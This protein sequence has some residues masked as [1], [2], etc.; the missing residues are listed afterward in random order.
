[1]AIEQIRSEGFPTLLV[2]CGGIVAYGRDARV[3]AEVAF[4]YMKMMGYDAINI[5]HK[6]MLIG[7]D[8]LRQ[9]SASHS[10]PS[11]LSSN[12]RFEEPPDGIRPYLIRE[13]G[14]VR[15]GILGILSD[16]SVQTEGAVGGFG[17]RPPGAELEKLIP[18][19]R[20]E[21]DV[22][23]LL[24]SLPYDETREILDRVDSRIDLVIAC[25]PETETPV[26][27]AGETPFLGTGA[28]GTHLGFVQVEYDPTAKSLAVRN[29]EPIA[30]GQ[31]I[32]DNEEV[33]AMIDRK[34]DDYE[35]NQRLQAEMLHEELASGL[36]MTP[37]EFLR[38]YGKVSRPGE[39]PGEITVTIQGED[40]D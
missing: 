15:V 21:A 8:Y 39:I 18:N 17:V 2:D 27:Y 20:K 30:L 11:F 29:H 22:I 3:K 4:E 35:R 31:E 36:N 10:D 26:K 37:Q 9:A 19:L 40:C 23:L 6:E 12:L 7:T 16:Q 24:S 5:G 28:K 32:P 13:V 38:Q 33:I 1:M 25:D 14:G 34:I